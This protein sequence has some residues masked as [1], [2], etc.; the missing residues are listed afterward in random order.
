MAQQS[1]FQP[2]EPIAIVGVGCRFAG[3]AE[4]PESFWDVLSNGVDATREVPADRWNADHYFDPDAKTRKGKMYTRRAAFLDDITRFDPTVFGVSPREAHTMD[5]QQ[6]VLLEVTVRQWHAHN[7][8]AA[9]NNQA[10]TTTQPRSLAP[11]LALCHYYYSMKHLRMLAFL[12]PS[13][14]AHAQAY[15]WAS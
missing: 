1:R 2:G 13:M 8:R 10:Y 3:G 12:L 14:K 15:T 4:S 9:C 5:P 6:R 11:S 7:T